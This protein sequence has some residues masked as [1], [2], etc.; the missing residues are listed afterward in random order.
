MIEQPVRDTF[1]TYGT[2]LA[3]SVWKASVYS[4]LAFSLLLLLLL[5]VSAAVW[6]GAVS[7]PEFHPR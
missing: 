7:V 5:V 6:A 4:V 1:K 3:D 2:L